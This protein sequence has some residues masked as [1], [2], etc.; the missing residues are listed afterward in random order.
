MSESDQFRQYAEGALLWVE[1]S[2]TERSVSCLSWCSLD[3]SGG[4][5]RRCRQPPHR[6]FSGGDF[7]YPRGEAPC[8]DF[9]KARHSTPSNPQGHTPIDWRLN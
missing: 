1:H 5:E 3:A 8:R 2:K 6:I 7:G 9:L 4:D